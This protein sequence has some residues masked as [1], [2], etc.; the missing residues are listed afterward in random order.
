MAMV[1][2]A[3]CKKRVSAKALQC[4]HCGAPQEAMLAKSKTNWVGFLVFSLGFGLLGYVGLAVNSV[5]LAEDG[6]GFLVDTTRDASQY[7]RYVTDSDDYDAHGEIFAQAAITL[8]GRGKC[9]LLDFTEMGGWVK[10][11]AHKSEPVY[12]T[13][14]GEMKLDN[15]IYLDVETAEVYQ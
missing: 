9:S 15:R 2:C 7:R 12:F 13:Y 11:I 14:C 3:E 8:V 10:S 5:T 4:P 1:R 6:L